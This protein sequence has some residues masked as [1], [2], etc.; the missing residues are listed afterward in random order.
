MMTSLLGRIVRQARTTF[1]PK[2]KPVYQKNFTILKELVDG[3]TYSN[4]NLHPEHISQEAFRDEE[5]APC[6]FV[7]IYETDLFTLTVFI[8]RAG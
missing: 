5:R 8:L 3:L 7:N 6:T 1:E 2:N 4:L